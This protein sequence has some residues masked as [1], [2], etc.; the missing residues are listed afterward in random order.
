MLVCIIGTCICVAVNF[1][2]S[3]FLNS[4]GYTT[5]PKNNGKIKI[6]WNKELTTTYASKNSQEA[7]KTA[8]QEEEF[9]RS[10]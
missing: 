7:Y 3:F 5:V 6:N 8:G 10:M 9:D 1:C 2:F 4:L